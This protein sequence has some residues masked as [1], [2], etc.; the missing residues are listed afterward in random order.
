MAVET[1]EEDAIRGVVER[2]TSAYE[3]TC[4]PEQVEAA[5]GAAHTAFSERPV[6][7]FVPVL[8]ERK[9]RALLNEAQG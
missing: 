2:L 9:A 3:K 1:R 6:R 8:V 7:D 4:T 5:V